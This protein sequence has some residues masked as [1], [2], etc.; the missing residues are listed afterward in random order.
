MASSFSQDLRSSAGRAVLLVAS[1]SAYIQSTDPRAPYATGANVRISNGADRFYESFADADPYDPSHLVACAYRVSGDGK[2]SDVYWVSF[3]SGRTWRQTLV[4]PGSVDPS[5]TIDGAGNV[6][7]GSIR[8]VPFPDGKTDSTIAVFRSI[9]RGRHWEESTIRDESRSADRA[10]VTVDKRRRGTTAPPVFVHAYLQ[11]RKGSSNEQPALVLYSSTDGARSFSRVVITEATTFSQPWFFLAPGAIAND[12]SLIAAAAEL[13]NRKRNMSYRTD[14]DSA[15]PEPNGILLA[16]RSPDSRSFD[17]AGSIPGV[18]YDWRIPQLSLPSLAI[19][20]TS[21][22][23]QGRVYLAWPDARRDGYV[24]I[25]MSSSDDAGRHWTAPSVV[26]DQARTA[27]NFM[28]AIA[29][30]KDGVVGAAWYD[31][32]DSLDQ[33]SY[34]VRFA[35]SVD[36]GATWVPSTKVSSA[37]HADSADTRKNSGDTAGLAADANGTFHPVWIDNRTG[38]PQVWTSAVTVVRPPKR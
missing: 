15:P 26:A 10:F 9:D 33:L 31:R 7:A 3:D 36:G 12:G 35:A 2:I 37:T 24:Q 38:S 25:L 16:V 21:G 13:D 19:D 27:N 30:A 22:P 4:V 1:I 5:C 32:R 17:I 29:V 6:V 20:R 14:P 34:D 18:R 11:Q 8:D 23:H 28:P